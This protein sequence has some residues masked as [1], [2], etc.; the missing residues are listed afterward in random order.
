MNDSGPIFAQIPRGSRVLVLHKDIKQDI[1]STF[2]L[3]VTGVVARIKPRCPIC[4]STPE[5][6]RFIQDDG[7]SRFQ[8][9]C[10]LAISPSRRMCHCNQIKIPAVPIKSAKDAVNAWTLFVTLSESS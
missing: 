4:C 1:Q 8:V 3:N 7:S 10:A 9:I 5:L 6:W 2:S